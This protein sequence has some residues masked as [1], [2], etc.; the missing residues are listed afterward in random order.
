MKDMIREIQRNPSKPNP[1]G[2]EEFAQFRLVL[3][4]HRFK[5]YRHLVDG[6]V[7]SVYSGFIDRVY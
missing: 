4:L 7:K 1:F 6:I 3:G 2:T 5:L